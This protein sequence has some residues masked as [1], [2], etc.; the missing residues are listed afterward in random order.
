[1]LIY[2]DSMT[3]MIQQQTKDAGRTGTGGL[4]SISAS[5]WLILLAALV[6]AAVVV[7]DAETVKIQTRPGRAR[8][9]VVKVSQRYENAAAAVPESDRAWSRLLLSEP[10]SAL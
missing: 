1:M 8:A 7:V 3:M 6:A 10:P 5:S 9:R 4:A 2:S